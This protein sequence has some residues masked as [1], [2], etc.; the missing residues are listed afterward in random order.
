[1]EE[2]KR[3]GE[4]FNELIQKRKQNDINICYINI[5]NIN[6]LINRINQLDNTIINNRKNELIEIY[7]KEIKMNIY[8]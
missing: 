7:K 2:L 8:Y 6:N 5:E 1:M 4:E 3:I